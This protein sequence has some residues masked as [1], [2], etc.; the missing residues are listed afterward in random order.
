MER[1]TDSTEQDKNCKMKNKTK[2][3]DTEDSLDGLAP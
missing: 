2:G 3:H 1:T